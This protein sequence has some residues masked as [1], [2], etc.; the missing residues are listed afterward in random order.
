MAPLTIPLN[1]GHRIPWLGF[2]TGTALLNKD[3]ADA[4]RNAIEHGIVHLD[5]AE[6]YTNEESL[7]AGIAAAGK[8]RE[9]LFVT[10]KVFTLD[11]G[12]TVRDALA[13]SLA[14]LG[15]D[16]VDLF[17]L[18]SP[19]HLEGKVLTAWKELEG[20]QKEG[21]A[22]SIG[23]SNFRV[24]DLEA[25]LQVAT[26][27]PAVNQVSIEYHPYVFKASEPLLELH[28]KHN[29]L[30]T[31][32]GGLTPLVYQKG[33]PVDPVLTSIRERLEKDTGKHVTEGQVLGLWLRAQGIPQITTS[34]KLERVKEYV[35]TDALPDL[36]PE[37]V[38]AINEAGSQLHFRYCVKYFDDNSW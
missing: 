12:R 21:L 29:I 17:L 30:T 2:G 13:Q 16:Y 8:P 19:K 15:L 10:S 23:V 31:S 38:R 7:G 36:T 35:A 24:K 32:Y 3:A 6:I 25:L 20:L 37:E 28:K 34:S 1:D 26:V 4:I 5:G 22:R 14:K 9:E 33:G 18:H 11:D 27:V